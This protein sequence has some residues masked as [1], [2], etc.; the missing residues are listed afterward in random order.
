M[1]NF[2]VL[3]TDEIIGKVEEFPEIFKFRKFRLLR[4]RKENLERFWALLRLIFFDYVIF[5]ISKLSFSCYTARGLFVFTI[6]VNEQTTNDKIMKNSC[7]PST[8]PCFFPSHF[9]QKPNMNYSTV[10]PGHVFVQLLISI[11]THKKYPSSNVQR[12]KNLIIAM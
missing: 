6:S 3:K 7:R 9:S 2:Q 1:K 5:I 10:G 12:K 4:W 8:S 11:Q